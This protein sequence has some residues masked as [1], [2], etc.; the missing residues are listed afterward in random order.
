MVGLTPIS[1]PTV[2]LTPIRGSA[3]SY[4]MGAY[5]CWCV[6][7]SFGRTAYASRGIDRDVDLGFGGR[8][9]RIC[10]MRLEAS[11]NT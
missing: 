3:L 10:N 8:L 5:D 11:T 1:V 6:D 2:S 7:R 4:Q 9:A